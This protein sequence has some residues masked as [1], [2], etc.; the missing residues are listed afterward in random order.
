MTNRADHTRTEKLLLEAAR[1]FNGTLVYEELIQQ[2]LR[3]VMT[4][5]SAKAALVFRIDHDRSDLKIRFMRDTDTALRVF[6]RDFGSGILGWVAHHRESVLLDDAANDPRVDTE[7][8]QQIG[9]PVRTLVSVPLIARGQMI[10]VMEAI[11]CIDGHFTPADLDIMIGLAHQIGVALDN[12]HLYRVARREALEK[13]LLLEIGKKLASPLR[14]DEVMAEILHSLSRAIRFDAGGVF[15]ISP[16]EDEVG[17]IYTEGYAPGANERVMTKLGQGLIGHVAKSGEPAVVPDVSKDPRYISARRSTQSEI[18]VPMMLNGLVIGVMNLESDTLG[19]YRTDDLSLM[20]AFAAQAAVSLDRARLHEEILAGKRL[21][22]QLNIAR[23]IQQ[24]FL[25]DE[26]PVIKDYDV[27][28]RNVASGQVGGDYYDFIKIVDNQYGIAIADVSGKGVPAALIM[29]SFR[30]SLIAEI[31]NNYSIRTIAQKVNNLLW[32]SVR[33]GSFVTAV[34]CVL[35]SRNHI[36]TFTNCGHN[37]PFLLRVDGQVEYLRE[38]GQVL[39]VTPNVTYEERPVFLAAGEIAVFYTDGVTEV[40]N[41]EGEEYGLDRLTELVAQNRTKTSQEL[42]DLIH[43]TV[44]HWAGPKHVFD[45]FT[46]IIL[47]RVS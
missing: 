8:Q 11:N 39:A 36:L 14:L 20:E 47:K 17:A 19:A 43:D 31:R 26:D 4:A 25:P 2:V 12:A 35:D 10:G 28:G 15:V 34:Y 1:I 3:L 29:A 30:A 46:M 38:G 37:L 13:H 45:D 41:A 7:I 44:K 24:S 21:E 33:A 6:H 5:V 40:F 22:E 9:E 23:E 16:N 32:E 42:V 18:V 27:S